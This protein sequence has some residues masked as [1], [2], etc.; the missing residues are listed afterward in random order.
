MIPELILHVNYVEQGQKIEEMCR[1]AVDWGYDGIEFRRK[2]ANVEEEPQ[3]YLDAIH[4]AVG[5]SGLKHVLFGTSTD[6]MLDEPAARCR[7]IESQI[8]FFE[9]AL[10][11]F[12]LT[13]CNAFC[14]SLLNPDKAVPYTEYTRHGSAIAQAKH[15]EQAVAGMREIGAFA[16]SR[17]FRLA[18]ETHM[19]Y[20]HDSPGKALEL[21]HRI[22]HPAIGVNLDY[23]NAVYLPDPRPL[24]EEI[25]AMGASLFYVHLKNSIFGAGRRMPT[26]L[27]EGEINHREYLRLLKET[28]FK[29]PIC[30]EAPRPGDREWYAQ[31]DIHYVRSLLADLNWR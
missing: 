18:F 8:K 9:M 25:T 5:K 20:L 21:V 31:E 13:V 3:A 11:R 12:P 1:R 14:G 22:N 24:D 2:R 15:W 16:Q 26:P 19:A 30:L 10:E 7:E 27:A 28:G 17:G 6:L 23:G 4:D 29:G